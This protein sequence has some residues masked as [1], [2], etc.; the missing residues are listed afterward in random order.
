MYSSILLNTANY[1]QP[2]ELRLAVASGLCSFYGNLSTTGNM[3]WEPLIPSLLALY[4]SLNDDDE[5]I[6]I[7]AANAVSSILKI[8]L[9]PP[10]AS[11]KFVNWL[12]IRCNSSPRF[13]WN[14]LY[15]ITG[16]TS[17]ARYKNPQEDRLMP[18]QTEFALALKEDDSL[19]AQEE[20]NLFIDDV[21]EVSLWG[22]LLQEVPCRAFLLPREWSVPNNSNLLEWD[23]IPKASSMITEFAV[24]VADAINVLHSTMRKDRPLGWASK[25]LAFKAAF[26]VLHCANV[27]LGYHDKHFKNPLSP[28]W[29]QLDEQE[30]MRLELRILLGDV[31]TALETFRNDSRI[32][33]K[34]LHPILIQELCQRKMEAPV[35]N[36]VFKISLLW[37]NRGSEFAYSDKS[38]PSAVQAPLANNLELLQLPHQTN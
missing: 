27:I 21:R 17:T 4:N 23:E 19:F 25:P 30:D 6:R 34:D 22:K 18:F 11:E 10:A 24:W 7:I 29:T 20:Q 32:D 8:S 3:N 35:Q 31:F 36:S 1:S 33:D 9:A 2:Y 37:K 14:I 28:A 15:R 26:R 12:N 16:S 13:I 5:E 38:D